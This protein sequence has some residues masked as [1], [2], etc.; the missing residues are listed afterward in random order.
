[1][2][3]LQTGSLRYDIDGLELPRRRARALR[4]VLPKGLPGDALALALRDRVLKPADAFAGA[5]V[6]HAEELSLWFGAQAAREKAAYGYK[7]V[8]TVW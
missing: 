5:D 1:V 7:L 6:V 2:Q 3:L 4:D 8:L